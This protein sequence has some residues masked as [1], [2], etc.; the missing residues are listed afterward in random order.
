MM[1]LVHAEAVLVLEDVPMFCSRAL[2][3]F[4][5][6]IRA[7]GVGARKILSTGRIF[8][9]QVYRSRKSSFENRVKGIFRLHQHG[10]IVNCGS[11]HRRTIKDGIMFI[12]IL[13]EIGI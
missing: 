5:G 6:V 1:L 9:S 4:G 7:V 11:S 10:R 13:N 3:L 2:K 8:F 12:E